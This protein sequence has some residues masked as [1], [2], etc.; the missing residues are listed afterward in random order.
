MDHRTTT[1]MAEIHQQI[2]SFTAKINDPFVSLMMKGAKRVLLDNEN[3]T[4]IHLFA[5]SIREVM[6]YLLAKLAPD[7][8]VQACKWFNIVTQ[9][10]AP[11]RIQRAEYAIRGGILPDD[12]PDLKEFECE[13]KAELKKHLDDLSKLTHV[14]PETHIENPEEIAQQV[15]TIIS[16]L[17]DFFDVIEYYRT[18]IQS[19]VEESIDQH[20]FETFLNETFDEVDILS[21]HSRVEHAEVSK[22]SVEKIDSSAVHFRAEGNVDVELNYGSGGD[23]SR[24]EGHSTSVYFPFDATFN[25]NINDM[26][27]LK[28][29]KYEIDTSSW[30]E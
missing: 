10:G 13:A 9:N 11:S 24:G 8:E 14:R 7:E 22:I 20:I 25:A 30:C 12:F 5:L 18:E 19:M 3:P 16:A 21:T 28:D 6:G 17:L 4:R 26:K 1:L 23:R 29:A 2:D 27:A 15:R